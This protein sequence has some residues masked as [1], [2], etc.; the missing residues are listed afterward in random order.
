MI[1][2]ASALLIPWLACLALSGCAESEAQINAEMARHVGQSV[3]DLV[4]QMGVP[5]RHFGNKDHEFLAYVKN[6]QEIDGFGPDFGY[7]GF[8]YGGYGFGGFGYGGFGG[9]GWGGGFPADIIT[10]GCETDFEAN[11]GRVVSFARHGN[12]C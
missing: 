1:K 4:R 8:G 6:Y 12:D 7:G 9:W 3:T 11:S 10:Y 5:N 2:I